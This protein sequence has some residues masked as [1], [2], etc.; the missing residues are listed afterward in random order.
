MIR[1]KT[2]NGK[3][4]E[5]PTLHDVA[6]QLWQMVMVPEPTLEDWMRENAARAQ[7]WDG[8][9]LPVDSP[10]A[11]VRAMI[12]CGHLELLSRTL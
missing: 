3:E 7:A 8:S 9:V 12:A 11:H 6:V 2:P 10:D 4:I 1:V 5:A